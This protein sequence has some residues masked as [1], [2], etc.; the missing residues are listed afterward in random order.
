MNRRKRILLLMPTKTYR[1]SAFLA[2]AQNLPIEPVIG[3]ER[4]QALQPFTPGKTVTLNF[5]QLQTAVKQ[6][7]EF[8]NS[9]PLDAILPV[10]DET[11]LL[12][13]LAAKE[14]GLP[15]NS[16][17]ACKAVTEKHTLRTMLNKSGLPSP[18]FQVLQMNAKPEEIAGRVN[19]PCVL[20]PVF[21]SASRGVIRANSEKEFIEAFYRIKSILRTPDIQ[22]QGGELS[23][24]LLVESFVPGDEIAFEGILTDGKLK[25][26]AI[27]DKP[28]PLNGPYFEETIYV[29]P[30]RHSK[31][32][33]ESILT[34]VDKTCKA[35]G[36]KNGPV[37]AEL[38][39]N[40]TG[41]WI[42]EI[43]GR[44]IGGYCSQT[45]KF[46]NGM[47]LEELIL[48][49]T[50]GED[51]S[52]VQR[53]TFASGVMMLPIPRKGVLQSVEGVD[54]AKMVSGVQ[55]IIMSIP[56]SREVVPLPEGNRYLGFIFAKGNSPATVEEVLR[57]AH[58]HLQ[59]NIQ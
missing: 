26:L 57:E 7:E 20:K 15:Y 56:I 22:A 24:L 10:D 30:S 33:Q 17:T 4:R 58:K 16:I 51:I 8:S 13:A 21:L 53:E 52:D 45:L 46:E 6:I 2:A 1:A 31:L 43:A 50:I 54:E 55:N 29:T 49:Q 44:S 59:I 28:D 12:A 27:F 40:E 11:I 35:I 5:R 34:C 23:D 39:L 38:R 41:V 3:S 14:L 42:I 9:F 25:L 47:S 32:L 48:R 19:Y 36:L 37:H 18:D